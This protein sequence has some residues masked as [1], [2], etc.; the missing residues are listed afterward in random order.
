[1]KKENE[2]RIERLTAFLN[3][4][5]H[6]IPQSV[7]DAVIEYWNIVSK[8]NIKIRQE[9]DGDGGKGMGMTIG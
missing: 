1:M 5:E 2:E 7:R 3:K 9:E 6:N 8:G 4:P